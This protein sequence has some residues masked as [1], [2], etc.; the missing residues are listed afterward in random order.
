MGLRIKVIVCVIAVLGLVITY[1][2]PI[3]ADDWTSPTGYSDPD[4]SYD[5][6]ED[7]IK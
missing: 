7:V 5:F 1:P 4:T 6:E 3:L 2:I